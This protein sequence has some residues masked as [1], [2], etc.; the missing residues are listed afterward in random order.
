MSKVKKD[1]KRR[2]A[3]K[4]L[5]GYLLKRKWLMLCALIMMLVAN[6]LA[7]I[8]PKISGNAIDAI[9]YGN[10]DFDKVFFLKGVGKCSNLQG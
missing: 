9:A 1:S 3:V 10:T 6:L 2:G 7:L 8:G 5:A 4:R